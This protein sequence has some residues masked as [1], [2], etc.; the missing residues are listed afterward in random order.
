[1][2]R[3]DSRRWTIEEIVRRRIGRRFS[4]NAGREGAGEL[5]GRWVE[6]S[7]RKPVGEAHGAG[8]FANEVLAEISK[9][10]E[11]AHFEG[12]IRKIFRRLSGELNACNETETV[13]LFSNVIPFPDSDQSLWTEQRTWVSLRAGKCEKRAQSG[14]AMEVQSPIDAFV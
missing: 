8:K 12:P 3:G 13:S 9:N 2:G 10:C 7:G 4:R 14:A 5:V 6:A 11:I 1:V